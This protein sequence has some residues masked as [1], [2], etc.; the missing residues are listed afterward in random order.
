MPVSQ[1]LE[2]IPSYIAVIIT[3]LPWLHM[4]HSNHSSMC[5]V[6]TLGA[7]LSQHVYTTTMRN[8]AR[9]G[10]IVGGA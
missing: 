7:V 3:L 10:C 4:N 5:I 1:C 9:E 2:M 8:I 6:C